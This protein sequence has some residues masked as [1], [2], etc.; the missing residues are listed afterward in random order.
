MIASAKYLRPIVYKFKNLNYFS[1]INFNLQKITSGLDSQHHPA[2]YWAKEMLWEHSS[3]QDRCVYSQNYGN[4]RC[5]TEKNVSIALIMHRRCH[6]GA[7]SLRIETTDCLC[8]SYRRQAEI[9]R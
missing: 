3:L 8:I 2:I 5:H 4:D 9:L 6:D 7:D 1:R